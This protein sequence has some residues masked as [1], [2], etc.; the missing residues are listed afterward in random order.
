VP[1][2]RK[3]VFVSYAREDR[4]WAD[5]LV[6]FLAPWIRDKRVYLWD[7]SKIKPGDDWQKEI[8]SAIEEAAVAV[9]LVTAEFFDST[10]IADVE[11]P[12]LLKRARKQQLTIIW[13]AADYSGVAATDLSQFQAANDPSHPLAALPLTQRN[14]TM[15]DI[16]KK[17]ADAFTMRTLAGS[18]GIIDATTE[19]INAA[20]EA[21]K[22]KSKRKYRVQA[23]YEPSSDRIDF[24][25]AKTTITKEDF[26][27]L[28]KQDREFIADLED[29]LN[30]NYQSFNEARDGLG[31]AGGALDSKVQ[32]ELTRI[33]RLICADLNSIIN[34]L[35]KMHKYELE[36]H[37][38]RYRF[39]CGELKRRNKKVFWFET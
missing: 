37:Y 27:Y 22:P 1:K 23:K 33:A 20:L 12:L 4:K 28:P 5:K 25:N 34:F 15:V 31:K 2:P 35:S 3:A 38:G 21:R 13:V 8:K 29:S 18:L 14:K 7:D 10:Y 24:T 16:G 11:L 32:S 30:Q 19:P 6:K 39:I 36:D 9:L 17:V 26:K